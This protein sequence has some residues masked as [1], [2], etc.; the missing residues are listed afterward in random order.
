MVEVGDCVG[1]EWKDG[2]TYPAVVLKR[3]TESG[4]PVVYVDV[5]YP[6]EEEDGDHK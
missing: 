4:N 1:V 5:F 3:Y 2:D 6:R